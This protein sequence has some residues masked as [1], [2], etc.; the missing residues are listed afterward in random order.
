MIGPEVIAS[1]V[2]IGGSLLISSEKQYAKMIARK[3]SVVSSREPLNFDKWY[4]KFSTQELSEQEL[5]PALQFLQQCIG[6][7]VWRLSPTDRFDSEL[8][9][10]GPK[11]DPEG[12]STLAIIWNN[13]G[14]EFD[15]DDDSLDDIV[16]KT[17]NVG[18]LIL[19]YLALKSQAFNSKATSGSL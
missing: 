4:M 12:G 19:T 13:I 10:M 1:M 15:L 5:A 8:A 11:Y 9:Y 14:D 16:R 18:E 3:K 7:D 6:P 17:D 2:V